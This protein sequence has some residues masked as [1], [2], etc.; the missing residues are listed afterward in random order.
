VISNSLQETLLANKASIPWFN[1]RIGQNSL[2]HDERT[3][4]TVLGM[5]SLGEVPRAGVM[6]FHFCDEI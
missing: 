3:I 5:I 6:G 4:S 1:Q 2:T